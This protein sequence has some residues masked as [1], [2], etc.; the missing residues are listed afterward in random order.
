MRWQCLSEQIAAVPDDMEIT[1]QQR[2]LSACVGVMTT[3]LVV[4]PMDVVKTRF[5][6][7]QAESVRR[8]AARSAPPQEACE[9][10]LDKVRMARL[11][12]TCARAPSVMSLEA[13]AGVAP[14]HMPEALPSGTF[15]ALQHIASREGLRGL[16]RGL[17]VT[18]IMAV[19]STVLY[20]SAYD[21][22]LQK[23]KAAGF[24]LAVAPALSGAF[25]RTV[26]TML[27]APLDLLRTRAQAVAS[28]GAG[29]AKPVSA[30]SDLFNVVRGGGIGTLWRGVGTTMWRDVPFSMIYWV[31]YENL[32]KCLGCASPVSKE[33]GGAR[34]GVGGEQQGRLDFL[35]RSFV[36]GAVSGGVASVL[37]HP[38][39]VAKTQQQVL[40]R[41]EGG[42]CEHRPNARPQGTFAV[43]RSIAEAR[44][45][46]GLFLG[47]V[48]RVGKVA[49]SCAIMICSY[50]AGKI[51]F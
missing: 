46:P 4:T 40:L 29:T 1:P 16:Y 13:S 15:R 43:I 24:S 17:D 26:A 36:A 50:E 12:S 10:C 44:G 25:S 11:Y 48:A 27:M 47:N 30:L 35:A 5:Q 34:G 51:F 9:K 8:Q 21:E 6:A 20:Y 38:F 14:G 45:I 42:G 3:S 41:G 7:A 32:K 49:P 39:D 37:T 31:S 22:L 18:L 28:G 19:P 23:L 33:G 2:M